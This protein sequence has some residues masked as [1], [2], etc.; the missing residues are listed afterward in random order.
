MSFVVS[1]NTVLEDLTSNLSYSQP[2]FIQRF[3]PSVARILYANVTWD[4]YMTFFQLPVEGKAYGLLPRLTGFYNDDPAFAIMAGICACISTKE[5]SDRLGMVAVVGGAIATFLSTARL[6]PPIFLLVV[7]GVWL[8]KKGHAAKM[9]L[10]IALAAFAAFYFL[11]QTP[12]LRIA[13]EDS[14]ARTRMASYNMTMEYVIASP[15]FGYPGIGHVK[16]FGSNLVRA[17]ASSSYGEVAFRSG[18]LGLSLFVFALLC[19]LPNIARYSSYWA[20]GFSAAF[21]SLGAT[22]VFGCFSALMILLL[23]STCRKKALPAY[24]SFR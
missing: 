19:F 22:S 15:I 11:A 6:A 16:G 8:F 4:G 5:K 12:N 14:S 18:L 10:G 1:P 17:G 2:T 13:L 20:A 3:L 7:G 9:L 23:I 21:L 24:H